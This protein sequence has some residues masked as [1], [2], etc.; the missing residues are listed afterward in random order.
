MKLRIQ[1]NNSIFHLIARVILICCFGLFLFSIVINELP[2]FILSIIVLVSSIAEI[3]ILINSESV[4]NSGLFFVFFLYTLVVH[5]GFV[6]AL[7]LDDTYSTFQS[8]TSMAFL[9]LASYPKAV[10]V[11]NIIICSF[12]ASAEISPNT[13]IKYPQKGIVNS[14]SFGGY[15]WVD[16]ISLCTLSVGVLFLAYFVFSNGLWLVGYE[17]TIKY[18]ENTP[19]YSHMVVLTSLSIA[20]LFALGSDKAIKAG[21]IIYIINS[22]LHFSMG[23]RGE[24]LYAAVICFALYSIRYKTIR[25]KQILFYGGALIVLIPL[26]RII[27]DLSLD[28]Y[29]FNLFHSF[30][31]VLAEEGIE[32]SPFTYIVQY[33]DTTHQHT[34]GMTYISAFDDF[35][36]RRLGLDGIFLDQKYVIKSIMPYKGMGFSMVAELYYNFSIPGA[37]LIYFLFGQ[38]I[39]KLD[40]LVYYN[41]I[42]EYEHI[43]MSMFMVEMINL[44]RNDSSTLPLYLFWI[45]MILIIC[46]LLKNV[47]SQN[48]ALARGS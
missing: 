18:T 47:S 21:V 34:W 35:F 14:M 10:A 36:R 33:V 3:V 17:T 13:I 2:I 44:T 15:K 5:N 45:L 22:I 37:M 27:R 42:G 6:I 1:K 31:D 28:S 48:T 29:H 30:L 26:V 8:A 38:M 23:N 40:N 4:Y 32:I 16:I 46:W 41:Q 43:F 7:L 11:S 25:G 9:E 20:L 12:A 24:V 39:K 19:L